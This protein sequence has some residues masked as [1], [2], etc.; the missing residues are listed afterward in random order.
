SP[1]ITRITRAS[2]SPRTLASPSAERRTV[3]WS[4]RESFLESSLMAFGAGEGGI[5]TWTRFVPPSGKITQDRHLYT[6]E[7]TW[8]KVCRATS[9]VHGPVLTGSRLS[10][11]PGRKHELA[12]TD[13]RRASPP[14][15]AGPG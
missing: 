15:V 7:F 5:I 9:V 12:R 4:R 6:A 14:F 1:Q 10:P 13:A 2:R 11:S 8:H 3:S